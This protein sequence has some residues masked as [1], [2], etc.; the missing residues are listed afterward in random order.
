MKAVGEAVAQYH[1]QARR[2]QNLAAV[3][4]EKAQAFLGRAIADLE[5]YLAVG[6]LPVLS[7]GVAP[8]EQSGVSV[9]A[10]RPEITWAE[11]RAI[12]ERV[13]AGQPITPEDL[14]LLQ[15][16]ASDLRAETLAEDEAWLQQLVES[17]RYREAMRDSQ[18]AEN[19]KEALLA[20]LKAIN[21]WRSKP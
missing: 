9:S 7:L 19:L 18:E 1:V 2:L 14:R 3:H 20:M 6:P 10:Y 16:P 15:Q 11:K 4:T 12:I 21:Y 13:D 8:S 5:R 17:E